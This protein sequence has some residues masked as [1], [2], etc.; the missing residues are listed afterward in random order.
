MTGAD[1]TG[2]RPPPRGRFLDAILYVNRTGIPWRHLPL[3]YPQQR[4][5]R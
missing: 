4:S 5:A 1:S 3:D 2:R